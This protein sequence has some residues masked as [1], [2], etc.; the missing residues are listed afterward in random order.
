MNYVRNGTEVRAEWARMDHT[1]TR[2]STTYRTTG[3]YVLLSKRLSGIAE[4]ARPYLLLDRLSVPAGEAYLSRIPDENA[5]ALGVR[6]DV[7][8]RFSVKGE[9]RSQ[10]A[11]SGDREQLLGL[12]FGFAF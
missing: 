4:R 5:W 11:P 9:F 8:T 1:L 12:Q 6:Y 2:Q 7:T 3:Y 10:L